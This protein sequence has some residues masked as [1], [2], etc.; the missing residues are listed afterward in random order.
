MSSTPRKKNTIKQQLFDG[1]HITV[2][3]EG[4]VSCSHC[5]IVF[6]AP[7]AS[8]TLIY[9]L[10]L[11]K[12]CVQM[13]RDDL[14]KNDGFHSFFQLSNCLILTDPLASNSR[15]SSYFH[16]S[17]TE[18]NGMQGRVDRVLTRWVLDERVSFSI[19]NSPG[20][21]DFVRQLNPTYRIPHRKTI[22]KRVSILFV[23][24]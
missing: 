5:N 16:S 11:A 7:A 2:N 13:K 1:K 8:A 4:I 19:V 9:H 12:N 21:Q 6:K 15:I 10:T 23:F 17:S 20:L 24:S 18:S 14:F 22:R 3:D